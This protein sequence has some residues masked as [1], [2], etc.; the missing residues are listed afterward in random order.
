MVSLSEDMLE[1]NDDQVSSKRSSNSIYEKKFVKESKFI[2]CNGVDGSIWITHK[3]DKMIGESLRYTGRFQEADVEKCVCILRSLENIRDLRNFIDIGANI[4]THSLKAAKLGFN[5]VFSIEPVPINFKLLSANTIMNDYDNI[6]TPINTAVSSSAGTVF[7]EL[8][9]SNFGDH[10]VKGG[11]AGPLDTHGEKNWGQQKVSTETLD[12]IMSFY[13]IDV[14]NGSLVWIDT[15]GHEGHVLFGAEQLRASGCP[16]AVEFWPYGL[17]RSGGFNLF[18]SALS[19]YNTIIDLKKSSVDEIS[20]I[21]HNDIDLIFED[22]LMAE[23]NL[24]SPHTDL[25]LIK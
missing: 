2:V 4:G 22:M 11:K 12:G 19:E 10:R 14:S 7:M 17:N 16:I 13:N 8:S 21:R 25:L 15:Q 1:K 5:A 6:I 24:D 9:P 3:D 23:T 18:K 20:Y